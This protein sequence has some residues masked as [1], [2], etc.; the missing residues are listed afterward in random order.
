MRK[1]KTSIWTRA[2]ALVLTLICV[3]GVL[4]CSAFAIGDT[5]TITLKR[6]GMSGV[7]YQS[8]ALGKCTIHQMY[9]NYGGNTSIGFCGEKGKGMGQSLIGQTWGYQSEISDPTVKMMMAYYYAHSTGV[10]TDAAVAAGVNTIWDAGYTWYM[11]AW[12][13]A[14]V[15]RYKEGTLGNPVQAC[16]EELMYVWNSLEG[17]GYTSIDQKHEGQSFRD[18][19]QYIID[20]GNQGIWGDCTVK[21]YKFT[22]TGSSHPPSNTVQSVIIG[23]LL[24]DEPEE[25]YTLI[26]RKVDSTNPTKV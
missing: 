12:V 19:A 1:A 23:D 16:A 4:P 5:E 17:K 10:F 8:A 14:I 11:N 18:R 9:Y 13:Q 7:S 22:G 26:V 15:W 3:I 25:Q 24:P 21:E 6:F 20:L 2:V